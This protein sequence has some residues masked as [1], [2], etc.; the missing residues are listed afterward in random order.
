METIT[1]NER[2]AAILFK[3]AMYATE[4]GAERHEID[5]CVNSALRIFDAGASAATSVKAGQIAVSII[6]ADKILARISAS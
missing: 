6:T 2:R 3:V 5:N 1:A 4:H